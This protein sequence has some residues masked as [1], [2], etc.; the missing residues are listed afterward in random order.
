MESL[1]KKTLKCVETRSAKFDNTWWE[2]RVQFFHGSR[3]I[4]GPETRRA[5]A[6]FVELEILNYGGIFAEN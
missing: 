1:Y 5:Y 3:K 4:F 2:I 6:A